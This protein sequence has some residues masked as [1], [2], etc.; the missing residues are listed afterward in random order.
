MR[1]DRTCWFCSDF[2]AC[3]YGKSHIEVGCFIVGGMNTPHMPGVRANDDQVWALS[4]RRQF[5]S[6]DGVHR[7]R[8]LA[9]HRLHDEGQ[10]DKR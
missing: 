2:S 4:F 1:M 6:I 10:R 8:P 9:R 5:T 3:W 7:A